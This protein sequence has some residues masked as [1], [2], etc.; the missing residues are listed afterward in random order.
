[1]KIIK[2]DLP[3]EMENVELHIFGDIH[4]GSNKCQYQELKQRIEYVR[5]KEN[6]RAIVLGDLI[7]NSTKNSVGDVYGEGLSPMEQI[8]LA[9]ELF[10]PIKEKIIGI[11]SGNHE[12]RTYRMDGIDLIH[13][14]AAELGISEM[15][16]YAAILLLVRYGSHSSGKNC[17]AIYCTHGDG[18]SGA[19]V[20][21]KANGL[22]KRG[23]VVDADVF[24]TG[25]THQPLVF[26]QAAMRIDKRHNV[27]QQTEQ[28]FVNIGSSLKYEEYAEIIGLRPSSNR[29]PVVYLTNGVNTAVL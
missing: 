5:T 23:N 26:T 21:G 9:T 25:H 24:I 28:L 11:V 13:F 19:T 20:G 29:D 3:K 7:N 10:A 12:R 6:A 22:Q 1:M 2:V 27:V 14:F 17:T 8:K 16:D 4:I 18:T 15:Y